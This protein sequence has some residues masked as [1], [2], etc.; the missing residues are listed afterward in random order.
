VQRQNY[1]TAFR[2]AHSD[3]LARQ[4]RTGVLEVEPVPFVEFSWLNRRFLTSAPLGWA[5]EHDV[6][7]LND[8]SHP[9]YA[10]GPRLS[11]PLCDLPRPFKFLAFALERDRAEAVLRR[12]S[13]AE[14]VE[15]NEISPIANDILAQAQ[16]EGGA[17][18]P[19]GLAAIPL[20]ARTSKAHVIEWRRGKFHA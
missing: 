1:A 5:R 13:V 10:Y 7:V 2:L 9:Q 18:F 6:I 15:R 20:D 11:G 19:D 4:V 3:A 12:V 14:G 16:Q 8:P 17:L